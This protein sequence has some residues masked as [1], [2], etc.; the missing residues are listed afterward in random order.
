M[1][2]FDTSVTSDNK[3]SGKTVKAEFRVPD[4]YSINDSDSGEGCD[5]DDGYFIEGFD[6]IDPKLM[7]SSP[8]KVESKVGEKELEGGLKNRT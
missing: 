1:S 7:K 3:D 5:M 6:Y 4:L 8:K 2:R